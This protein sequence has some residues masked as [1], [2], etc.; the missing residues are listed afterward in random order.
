L[1]GRGAAAPLNNILPRLEAEAEILLLLKQ[2]V[3]ER[4][5]EG[6]VQIRLLTS[7]I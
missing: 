6:E 5:P 4:E 7:I 1:L 3:K 2:N